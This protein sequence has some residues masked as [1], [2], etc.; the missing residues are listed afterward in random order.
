MVSILRRSALVGPAALLVLL[1]IGNSS[2]LRPQGQ[3]QG[4][5]EVQLGQEVF[6]Q[7]RAKGENPPKNGEA[8]RG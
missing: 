3:R 6:D 2:P 4:E 1:T 5:D 8:A 7:L